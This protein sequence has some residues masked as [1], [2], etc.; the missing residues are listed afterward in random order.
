[1]TR[2]R[3]ILIADPDLEVARSL[4][5]GLGEHFDILA[6]RDGSKALELSVLRYPDLILFY[7]ACPLIGATQFLRIL[8][9]NPRTEE[10]PLIILSDEPSA[11]SSVPGFL[12][13]VLVKPLNIDEVRAH[14]A[15]VLRRVDA[16]KEVGQEEGAVSGGLEQISMVDLLQVFAMNRRT[17]VLQLSGGPERRNAEV[18]VN[19]G[20]IEEAVV[21]SARGE[22][23]LYRLLGWRQGRFSFTPDRRAPSVSINHTTDT[24]LMEGMRQ[25]DELERLRPELPASS[26]MV[27]RCVVA[28]DT[29]SGL[30][31]V[32]AEILELLQFYP[33]VADLLDRARA[34]DL[35]VSQALRSLIG[36]GLARV[37][38][39]I[40]DPATRR[41]FTQ[42]QIFELRSRLRR[43]GLSPTYLNCPKIAVV[44][45]SSHDLR[46]L[47]AALS[48]WMEFKG[49]D[50]EHVERMF[51]GSF[52]TLDFEQG[53]SIDLF[54]VSPDERMLPLAFASSAGTVAALV[55]GTGELDVISGA[56]RLLETERRASMVF[57]RR[58][59][60]PPP[61]AHKRRTV[62]EV[63]AINEEEIHR[64][65]Q[66]VLKQAAT[67]DLRGV[68][69]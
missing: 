6:A 50:L 60:E 69:L 49:H 24:L 19:E 57:V 26:A 63:D 36:A 44:A 3:T 47:G 7:R 37:A 64:V 18:Y 12:E 25:N 30:H 66:M 29:P 20:R 34:T 55:L 48:R 51:F 56:L 65:M 43:A 39:S 14:V 68:S 9:T 40:A 52:G 42:E 45:T 58:S 2:R 31:P 53:F 16:V 46:T 21:G 62:L 4:K 17:G 1:M 10:I 35:E 5:R 67:A 27:E 33:R 15:N 11:V 13:G 54:A 23:A 41:L 59:H 22:K 38:R 28:E 8:R 61:P 32:T